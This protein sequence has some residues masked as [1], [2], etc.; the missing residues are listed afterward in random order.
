M[1]IKDKLQKIDKDHFQL[2]IDIGDVAK[3]ENLKAYLVGGMA[4]DLL[5]GFDNLDIDITVENNSLTLADALVKAFPN[6]KLSAKHDRFHTA[7]LIFN[8]NGKLIPVDLASTREETYKHPAALPDVKVSELKKDLIRRDFTINALAVSLLPD[9]FGEVVDLFGGLN[10]LKNKKIKILHDK[11]FIDD[12]TRMIR[13]VR[14]AEKLDFE[15]EAKT[16]NLL[17]EAIESE[18]FDNLIEKIRGDRVKIEIRYLFNLPDVEKTINAFS[19]SGIYKMVSTKLTPSPLS[20]ISYRLSLTSYPFPHNNQW[21]I[22]LALLLKDLE[23]NIRQNIMKNLQLAGDETSIIEKAYLAS[24]NLESLIREKK[25][26]ILLLLQI[27]EC[28]RYNFH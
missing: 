18:Q 4:R 11:S 21:L 25:K 22:I 24:S 1:T 3:K 16:Q 19:G 26:N 27:P 7:K 15:I 17:N 5:L 12:P 10:D 13:A 8:V 9:N 2:L 28:L 23:N 6:C 14:F 20:L